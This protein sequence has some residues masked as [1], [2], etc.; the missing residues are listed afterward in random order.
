MN[1]EIMM[2]WSKRDNGGLLISS[3]AF[4]KVQITFM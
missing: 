2:V 3:R 1:W 4:K